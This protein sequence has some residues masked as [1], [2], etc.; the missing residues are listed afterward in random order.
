MAL[1]ACGSDKTTGVNGAVSGS[2]SFNYSGGGG[3]GSYSAT[4]SIASNASSQTANTTQWAAA[5][6]D[7]TDG[8]VNIGANK[9]HTST[10]SDFFAIVIAGQAVGNYTI[11]PDCSPTS[12]T[13]CTDVVLILDSNNST[14]DFGYVC[15]LASGT[16]NIT[17]ISG[18]NVQGTFSGTGSCVLGTS[19]F[20]ETTWTV[21]NGSFNTPLLATPPSF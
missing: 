1:A 21:T 10:A 7:N 5:Y 11:N 13:A 9:P 6:K 18:T 17:S 2:V 15:V 12:T 8:S 3:A 16:V 14:S 20:T 4:G 19:P